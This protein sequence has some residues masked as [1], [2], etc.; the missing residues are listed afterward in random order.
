MPHI[1]LN[2]NEFPLRQEP[3]KSG[4]FLPVAAAEK[5]GDALKA[6]SLYYKLIR[7]LVDESVDTEDLDDAL[8]EMDIEEVNA[9]LTEATKTYTQDPTSP[10]QNTSGRSSGGSQTGE[11]TS[12]VVSFSQAAG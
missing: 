11:R 12:R 5:S 1:V 7:R 6:M 10:V 9:A 4:V 8:S 3:P 2:G